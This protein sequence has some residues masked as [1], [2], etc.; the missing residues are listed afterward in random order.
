MHAM[1]V[2]ALVFHFAMSTSN[3]PAH[4]AHRAR[5]QSVAAAMIIIDRHLQ[6]AHVRALSWPESA[7]NR[8]GEAVLG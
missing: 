7:T 8:G 1:V 5:Q 6:C 3:S 2:A 4:H